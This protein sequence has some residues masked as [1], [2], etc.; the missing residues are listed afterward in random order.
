[1]SDYLKGS[2]VKFKL[3]PRSHIAF[4]VASSNMFCIM[5]YLFI[6]VLF[7]GNKTYYYY[8]F[9]EKDSEN[10]LESIDDDKYQVKYWCV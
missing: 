5:L 4:L 8:Y 3:S 2:I 10:K 9:F 6:A 1:M 7:A